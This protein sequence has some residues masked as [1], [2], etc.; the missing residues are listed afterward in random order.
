MIILVYFLPNTSSL[1][2]A[3][4]LRKRAEKAFASSTLVFHE[5]RYKHMKFEPSIATQLRYM[6]VGAKVVKL[7]FGWSFAGSFFIKIS[8]GF[9]VEWR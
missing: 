1:V 4:N 2:S 5:V 9:Q 7:V 8:T 6:D 3:K